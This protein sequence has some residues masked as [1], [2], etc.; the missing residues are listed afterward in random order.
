MSVIVT[1][2]GSERKSNKPESETIKK[3]TAPKKDKKQ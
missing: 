3:E 1:D 2:K